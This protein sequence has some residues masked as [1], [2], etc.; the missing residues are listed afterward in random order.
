MTTAIREAQDVYLQSYRER[1][2]T[3]ARTDPAWLSS[4]RTEAIRAFADLGFPTTHVEDWKY[5]SVAAIARAAFEAGR[6]AVTSQLAAR[7]EQLP[8]AGI[9]AHRLVF[10]NGHFA[11]QLSSLNGLPAGIK[12]TSLADALKGSAPKLEEHLA[13]HA[14]FSAHPFVALNTAF[15]ED[16]AYIEIPRGAVVTEPIHIVYAATQQERPWLAHPRSFIYAGAG[17]E[18]TVVESYIGLDGSTYFTNTVTEIVLEENAHVDHVKPQ[19]ESVAAYHIASIWA[20]QARNSSLRTCSIA[21]GS[22][23]GRE[24]LGVVLD[25][26]GAE[27]ILSGLYV[28]SGEQLIDNHTTLD[29]AQPH[30]SSRE[31]Y[32]GVLDGHSTGVFNGKI[33]VRKDAQKTDSKQS[34]RNLL[35]SEGAT[36]NTKPQLEIFADDVKCTHGATIGQIDQ[37]AL[38]YMRS[39]GIGLE[40]ARNLLVVAFAGEIIDRIR[41]RPLG[42]RLRAEILARFARGGK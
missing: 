7:F 16:G 40:E 4:L 10:V 32:K 35:L 25:G 23:L 11:P 34:N 6:G 42:E 41:F 13:R 30:C 8:Y 14:T 17:S 28:T 18:A 9:A 29:H 22:L 15:I 37:D 19:L 33:L 39:R 26:E 31:F 5:T 21:L 2:S 1:E 3:W 24:E 27:S 38:F 12:V 36:V 20:H